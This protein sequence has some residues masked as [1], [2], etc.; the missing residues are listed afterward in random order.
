M[1]AAEHIKAMLNA[2][3]AGFLRDQ[4]ARKQQYE[5]D[6]DALLNWAGEVA[7]RLPTDGLSGVSAPEVPP[8]RPIAFQSEQAQRVVQK[9]PNKIRKARDLVREV[10]MKMSP[11][12]TVRQMKEAAESSPDTEI[13][14][15]DEMT[16]HSTMTWFKK[17]NLVEVVRE[18]Q[19]KTE[20]SAYRILA[21]NLKRPASV[22]KRNSSF[23]LIDMVLDAVDALSPSTF[24]KQDTFE[25][26]REL[27]P[28]FADRIKADSV[29][30][31]LNKLAGPPYHRIRLVEKGAGGHGN[32]YEKIS[33]Q[34]Q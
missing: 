14:A 13:R 22:S 15:L 6:R 8:V 30:A 12:F 4:D 33:N 34:P 32:T 16:L 31:T 24:G 1:N 23:P 2:L 7:S 19:S 5:R 27:H 26:T 29:S 11:P 17:Y 21:P 25:K 20:G 18:R 10:A 3:E 9:S 28:D